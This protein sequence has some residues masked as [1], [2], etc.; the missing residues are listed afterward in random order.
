MKATSDGIN[1]VG[2]KTK[3]HFQFITTPTSDTPGTSLMLNFET[4]RYVFG[5]ITEG[6]Q[7]ACIQRGIGLRKVRGLFLLGKTTWNNAG[8]IGLILTLADVQHGEVEA[9]SSTRRP[10]LRIYGGPKQ[11][12][13]LACA[14]RFVFRTGMPLSVYEYDT[15]IRSIDPE[16]IFA[17]ENIRV[18]AIAVHN[19]APSSSVSMDLENDDGL[20]SD[21]ETES[22]KNPVNQSQEKADQD[23]RRA[24]VNDM[25]DSGWKVDR[26]V[27]SKLK[28]IR[29]PAVV[30]VRNPETKTLTS[31]T[32]FDINNINPLTPE[33]DILV[34]NPWPASTV[35]ELPQASYLP[36]RVA[37]SYIAKGHAQRGAFNPKKATSLGLKP[38][39]KFRELTAGNSVETDDGATITPEM[40][41]EP[42]RPGK[43]MAI[44]DIPSVGYLEDLEQQI[45]NQNEGL[46]EGVDSAVWM[47]RGTVLQSPRF[48]RLL[49]KFKHMKHVISDPSL[50]DDYITHDSSALSCM[51]LS[52]IAPEFF[53]VPRYTGANDHHPCS[54]ATTTS[55]LHQ[56][57]NVSE[58]EIDVVPAQRG[59]KIQIVPDL[60]IDD[61][62][63]PANLDPNK[64][65]TTM[66]PAVRESLPDDTS[67]FCKD[68]LT[69]TSSLDL[70]EPEII[71]LGTGSSAPSKYRNVSAVLL[72]MPNE[73]GNYLFDCGE[74][75]MGQLK[76]LYSGEQLDQILANLKI[77][78][79][80]HLHADHHLGTISVLRAA[81]E[82]RRRLAKAGKLCPS[83]PCL[84]SEINMMDYMDEYQSVLDI[85]TESLCTPVA[86]H[87]IEGMTVR[88]EKF[89]FTQTDIPITELKTVRVNHCHGSQAISVTFSSGFKFSYSGDCRPSETFCQIGADSDVLVHEATFDDGMEGDA[90][91]KK[92]C[93]TGEAVGV[94]L[95]MR[96]K[97]L[98]L[99]HFS[100]R[101]QKIP[102][103]R[104][105]KLPD[106]TSEED[107]I[108]DVDGEMATGNVSG[109]FESNKTPPA[110]GSSTW[111]EPESARNLSIGFAFDLMR[112]KVSQIQSMKK[113]FPAITKMFEI[114]EEKREKERLEI[115]AALE[116]DNA[117]KRTEKMNRR[118]KQKLDEWEQAKKQE[119]EM[120]AKKEPIDA[121]GAN[122]TPNSEIEAE[123]NTV[124]GN[125]NE[126]ALPVSRKRR[127]TNSM[128]E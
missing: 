101:Y 3:F 49:Q 32:V 12:H 69:T 113:I 89:D 105:I 91:A 53:S 96:A 21:L 30:W 51:R 93:T 128:V 50:C 62:E 10:R 40:V 56:L 4:K 123:D 52:N 41:L 46:F 79:I 125:G 38:G 122:E 97:N 9:E 99:T 81:F 112:I 19:A 16:P 25:F 31:H 70:D 1:S 6:T 2:I 23:L 47:T 72:R 64:A 24:I 76:C 102:V 55:N 48:Q 92:H 43:G 58:N 28:D 7:R 15:R 126:T 65:E 114:A 107:L 95:E 78:W 74:G 75:T 60:V 67:P 108:D 42:T 94:A 57:L 115:A 116:E 17:D 109:G 127:K 8:L 13:S 66:E 85:P 111:I 120:C 88:G 124:N 37:M 103:I 14:R 83:P 121:A 98:I 100:Q 118:R 26:L 36:G 59:L 119:R 84:I 29:L 106:R 20:D 117:R 90:M 87:W 34:R 110:S 39:P 80:S 71:T 73:M 68:I 44:F 35:E 63:V 27:E 45:E 104:N 82:A 54:I 11:L 33:S 86:C 18:W 5:E 22:Q 61:R 77:I